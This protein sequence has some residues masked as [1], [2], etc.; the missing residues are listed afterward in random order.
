MA[1]IRL[2]LG[3]LNIA[4]LIALGQQVHFA[5]Y[6][7]SAFAALKS[8]VGG[9]LNEINEMIIAND[10][11][12]A[13]LQLVQERLAERQAQRGTLENLLT[14][15]ANGVENISGGNTSLIQS[16]G[17]DVPTVTASSASSR[18]PGQL[19]VGMES[20]AATN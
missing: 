7:N 19:P 15:L 2:P 1:K 20:V 16:A 14:K 11:Y 18:S 9:L 17:F 8:Q 6:G 5:M 4:E 13:A 10:G 12:Q 3:N